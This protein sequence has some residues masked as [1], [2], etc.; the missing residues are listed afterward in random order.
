MADVTGRLAWTV[1]LGAIALMLAGCD[2]NNSESVTPP[3]KLRATAQTA[4]GGGAIDRTH[5]G[6]VL[7]D[8][9]FVDPSGRSLSL[10]SLRGKPV[11][12]NLWATWCGPCVQEM[13]T[14][15]RIAT[16]NAATLRIVTVSQD[17][18]GA[19]VSQF[20]QQ[21]GFAKLE[22]WLDPDGKL[23]I[24][25]GT[26]SLPTSVFYD[27]DGREVWRLVGTRDWTTTETT[28]LLLEGTLQ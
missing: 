26:G 16:E 10:S 6:S 2:R 18:P 5:K 27:A 21:N 22:P 25:F 3:D 1:A 15:D 4:R 20:F 11:L 8:F 14:L 24:H 19:P 9:T 28:A 12:L 7:P 13:P 23:D 17:A